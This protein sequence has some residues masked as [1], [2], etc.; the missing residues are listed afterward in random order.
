MLVEQTAHA[1]P[2]LEPVVLPALVVLPAPVVVVVDVVLLALVLPVVLE[3]V[4]E[5][6]PVVVGPEVPVV[7]GP[8]VPVV[9]GPEVPVVS[10][11]V[12]LAPVVLAPVLLVCVPL[13]EVDEVVLVAWVPVVEV[14]VGVAGEVE[15]QATNSAERIEGATERRTKKDFMRTTSSA[16]GTRRR[17]AFSCRQGSESFIC[18][19]D[20]RKGPR[21]PRP[22]VALL[23]AGRVRVP[24]L[25][26]RHLHTW[27]A[28]T[29][30]AVAMGVHGSAHAITVN[31][32][33]TVPCGL[34]SGLPKAVEARAGE[35]ADR[36]R[37]HALKLHADGA[38][39]VT[40]ELDDAHG[41]A[42]FQRTVDAS[43]G[44]CESLT[45]SL[46][47]LATMWLRSVPAETT[48]PQPIAA[49]PKHTVAVEPVVEP[50]KI[51]PIAPIDAG[52]PLIDAG[53][54]DAGIELDAGVEV[55]V[56]DAGTL[57]EVV[58][59][60]HVVPVQARAW[61]PA[62]ADRGDGLEVGAA[63]FGASSLAT[64]GEWIPVWLGGA[65]DVRREALSLR[66][67]V[68]GTGTSS[69]HAGSGSLD[70]S[71]GF[72]G[73]R[74]GTTIGSQGFGLEAGPRV[75]MLRIGTAGY[76]V[77]RQYALWDPGLDVGV[78]WR[79]GIGPACWVDLGAVGT[80]RAHREQVVVD[81]LGTLL[82]VPAAWISLEVLAG[83]RAF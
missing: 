47:L 66:L 11:P 58:D 32:S 79:R 74:V 39:R 77:D 14:A 78:R 3:P 18:L 19:G 1:P 68:A 75:D 64:E 12:V 35:L 62:Y 34:S 63:F 16:G 56:V 48:P 9:L 49:P 54:V 73:L 33:G 37:A 13:V 45:S 31:S 55:Q 67:S 24:R 7:L 71:D 57:A 83:C 30:M 59:A 51:E 21:D 17:N 80:L 22:D 82:T 40:L 25:P 6:V 70:E 36:A 4:V 60:G 69:H 53:E 72:A 41:K 52:P 43:S 81:G 23:N 46:A 61:Q 8:E 38:G 5:L 50:R 28:A 44:S 29:A 65:V 27:F 10:V 42:L 2:P 26:S 15:P 76:A 20:S